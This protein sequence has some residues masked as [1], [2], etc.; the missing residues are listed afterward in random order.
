MRVHITTERL[1]WCKSV[2]ICT[3]HS[4]HSLLSEA[5]N[6]CKAETPAQGDTGQVPV[7]KLNYN[8]KN[9]Y[10]KVKSFLSFITSHPAGAQFITALSQISN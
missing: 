8:L 7:N 6:I 4:K 9:F 2:V 1:L 3:V 5:S 10:K